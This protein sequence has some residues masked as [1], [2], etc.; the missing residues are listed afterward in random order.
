MNKTRILKNI[1]RR[2]Y[3][4]FQPS[5]KTVSVNGI[6]ATFDQ[7]CFED[8][9]QLQRSLSEQRALIQLLDNLRDDDV[10]YDI[11]ANLGM[12]TVFA[13]K[14]ISK[15]QIV[16]FEP[17]KAAVRGLQ[18]NLELNDAD[19]IIEQIALSNDSGIET[20]NVPDI[21]GSATIHSF[22]GGNLTE[23]E[24]QT[25]VGDKYIQT[26]ALPTPTA[27]KID[28]EGHEGKVVRGLEKTFHHGNVRLLYCELHPSKSGEHTPEFIKSK[29]EGLG[30]EVSEVEQDSHQPIIRAEKP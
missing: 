4:I 8:Y 13:S 25:K 6:T 2:A 22:P 19:A 27:L 14:V 5:T 29:L 26:Q 17:S 10:F 24:I 28:V 21:H 1:G 12:Y 16:A 11:G 3:I 7:S 18:R 30:Y 20:L 9:I 23:Q 15:G